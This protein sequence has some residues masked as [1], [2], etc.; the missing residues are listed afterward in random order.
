MTNITEM[1]QQIINYLKNRPDGKDTLE[2]ITN[3]WISMD[4][5]AYAV[6]EIKAVLNILV[7]KGELEEIKARKDLF[8][9]RITKRQQV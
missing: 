6:D 9:Y 2:G 1:T 8:I 3:W 4:K 5:G 7:E